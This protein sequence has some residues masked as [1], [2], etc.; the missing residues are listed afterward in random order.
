MYFGT[1]QF[2]QEIERSAGSE[3]PAR[4]SG[5]E[6]MVNVAE[7]CCNPLHKTFDPA[8]NILMV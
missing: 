8:H 1:S 3:H 6:W 4:H 2:S 7:K 5:Y